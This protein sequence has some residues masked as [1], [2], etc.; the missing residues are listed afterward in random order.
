MPDRKLNSAREGFDPPAIDFEE[1]ALF[2]DVD[3]TLLDIASAP[4][5]VVVPPALLRA[6][7]HLSRRLSGALALVTGRD[8]GFIERRFPHY[9]GPVAALHG[10][11]LRHAS[12]AVERVAPEAAFHAARDFVHAAAEAGGLLAEDKGAA[13]A[14]HY[15]AAPQKAALARDIA[16]RAQRLAGPGWAV[17]PGKMVFELRPSAGDKGV[18]LSRLMGEA[19]FT[20]RVPFAFGDDLT[21]QPMLAAAAEFGGAGVAVGDAIGGTHGARFASPAALRAWLYALADMTNDKKNEGT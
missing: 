6:V 1:H 19:P 20:G 7:E 15:R 4:E 14:L 11:E 18:A 12:G 10:A 2:F 8:I 16:E 3:G 5:A 13:I 21:D 9:S 17:Q